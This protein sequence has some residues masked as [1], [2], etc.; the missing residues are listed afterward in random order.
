MGGMVTGEH[1]D[2]GKIPICFNPF[3]SK[4]ESQNPTPICPHKPSPCGTPGMLKFFFFTNL[5]NYHS[6]HGAQNRDRDPGRCAVTA[7]VADAPLCF[8]LL[9]PDLPTNSS[10]TSFKHA[11]FGGNNACPLVYCIAPGIPTF[12]WNVLECWLV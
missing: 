1:K 4:L 8:V 3:T 5:G 12:L 9:K 10:L 2:S 11:I 6:G 7:R